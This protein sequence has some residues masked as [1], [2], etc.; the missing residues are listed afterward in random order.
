MIS[1]G[2]SR[3]NISVVQLIQAIQLIKVIQVLHYVFVC[4]HFCIFVFFFRRF[5][6]CPSALTDD[7]PR[8]FPAPPRTLMVRDGHWASEGGYGG[9]GGQ[10][11][12]GGVEYTAHSPCRLSNVSWVDEEYEMSTDGVRDS[13]WEKLQRFCS[14]TLHSFSQTFS[15]KN[16]ARIAKA[17]SLSYLESQ[18]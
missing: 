10:Y 1:H 15:K 12:W 5:P 17:A 14:G 3:W 7:A 9:G 6:G 18:V 2:I 13:Q 11:V 8:W 4:L 16:I